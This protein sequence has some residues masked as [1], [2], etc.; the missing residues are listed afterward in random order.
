MLL[1]VFGI[2][3]SR[4]LEQ[5]YTARRLDLYTRY[6][7]FWIKKRTPC[8]VQLF[9]SWVYLVSDWKRTPE[10]KDCE[11]RGVRLFIQNTK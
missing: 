8:L 6:L 10:A 9:A 3:V 1:A 11:I 5:H 2:V 7:V 4:L